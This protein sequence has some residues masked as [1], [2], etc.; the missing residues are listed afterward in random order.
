MT[1][2]LLSVFAR[3]SRLAM[4][5]SLLAVA[6]VAI[7]E[8]A[9]RGDRRLRPCQL[10]GRRRRR[11]LRS[12]VGGGECGTPAGTLAVHPVRGSA[13][14]RWA[15]IAGSDRAIARRS[16]RSGHRDRR[17]FRRTAG[18]PARRP[19]PA[20]RR[21]AR[22]RSL[23]CLALRPA[24]RQRCRHPPAPSVPAAGGAT[25]R[26]RDAVARRSGPVHLYA[27]RARSGARTACAGLR[28]AQPPCRLVWH[29]RGAGVHPRVSRQRAHGLYGQR[30]ADGR[31]N[32][33]DDGKERPGPVRARAARVRDGRGMP[34]GV[35]A[36]SRRACHDHGP[37]RCR[38]GADDW[39][40]ARKKRRCRVDASPSGSAHACT[41]RPTARRCRGWFT[42]RMGATGRRS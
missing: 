10:P 34:R 1:L 4:G 11:V 7:A 31:A 39:D 35:S 17:A 29:A 2:C 6:T 36:H 18:C 33:A 41:G 13:G 30:G 32:A 40:S 21:S 19:G 9:T 38:R 28:A 26:A 15:C 23:R 22:H 3:A 37:S 24:C 20:V 5:L 8:E 42:G 12:A 14:D 27:C 16:R 25:V